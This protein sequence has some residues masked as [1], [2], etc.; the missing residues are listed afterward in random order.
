[1]ASLQIIKRENILN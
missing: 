1:M